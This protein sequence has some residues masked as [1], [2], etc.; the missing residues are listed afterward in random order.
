MRELM[1]SAAAMILSPYIP[2][3]FMGEEYGEDAPFMYFVDHSD[4]ELIRAVREGRKREF[5]H[6]GEHEPKDAQDE[7]TFFESKLSWDKRLQGDHGK[8]LQWYRDLIRL[9]RDLPRF[10]KTSIQVSVIAPRCISIYHE[11]G[12]YVFFNFSSETID[13]SFEEGEWKHIFGS[14]KIMPMCVSVYKR[15]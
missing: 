13:Y 14:E 7:N 10:T 15:S 12:I 2:M 6:M 9:R 3:L 5:A 11:Q 1:I 8:L 4:K